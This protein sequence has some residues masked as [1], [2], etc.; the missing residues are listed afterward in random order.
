[1]RVISRVFQQFKESKVSDLTVNTLYSPAFK[2]TFAE[3]QHWCRYVIGAGMSY[4]RDGWFAPSTMQFTY[5][6]ASARQL[7]IGAR[8]LVTSSGFLPT[9]NVSEREAWMSESLSNAFGTGI[10]V[11]MANPRYALLV[12]DGSEIA[13]EERLTTANAVR[14]AQLAVPGVRPGEAL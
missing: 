5:H 3:F 12:P 6:K 14:L 1:M 10:K 4:E 8:V 9:R 11:S 2:T 13:P 7:K